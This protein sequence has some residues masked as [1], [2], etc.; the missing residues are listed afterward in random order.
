MPPAPGWLS[1]TTGWPS[2]L[3]SAGDAARVIVS[4]PDAV[5]TGRMNL[6]ARSPICACSRRRATG[7]RR[8]RAR[9]AMR[10]A[11]VR[12]LRALHAIHGHRCLRWSVAC[13][14]AVSGD[15]ACAIS[16]SICRCAVA[17]ARPAARACA[18]PSSADRRRTPSRW[19]SSVIGNS[20]VFTVCPGLVAVGQADVGEAAGRV[21][22]RIVVEVLGLADRRERQPDLLEQRGELVGAAVGQPLAQRRR[23]ARGAPRRAGCWSASAG[24]ALRSAKPSASQNVTHCASLTAAQE[25]LL[26]VLDREHVVHRP[27]IVARGHRRRVLAG[28][29]ELQHV[30][31]HQEHVVLEQRRLHLHALGR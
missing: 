20:V 28:H 3:D 29:R 2:A 25:D 23:A 14:S 26:A 11:A 30:L 24:S 18:R 27:R 15:A 19:P 6:T 31:A 10:R 8:R 5:A 22:V 7:S 21:E 9:C 1:T 4:T 13:A 16:A 12:A 17:D